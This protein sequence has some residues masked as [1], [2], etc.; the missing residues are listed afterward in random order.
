MALQQHL[1][2]L[3]C[4]YILID[5]YTYPTIYYIIASIPNNSQ[6][7][8]KLMSSKKIS[9]LLVIAQ[10]ASSIYKEWICLPLLK[11]YPGTVI[12][13]CNLFWQRLIVS[14]IFAANYK[15]I[16]EQTLGDKLRS[17]RT[18]RTVNYATATPYCPLSF[19]TGDLPATGNPATTLMV[20]RF[21]R[22]LNSRYKNTGLVI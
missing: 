14:S 3:G 8:H 7:I 21:A 4:R 2:Q 19:Q 9:L 12:F 20:F 17:V 16:Q 1:Q 22:L 18:Y 15:P 11:I 6:I 13:W 10:V 5:Y